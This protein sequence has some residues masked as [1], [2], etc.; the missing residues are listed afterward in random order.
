M[1]NK[2][3]NIY[4]TTTQTIFVKINCIG[5]QTSCKFFLPKQAACVRHYQLDVATVADLPDACLFFQI[6]A[7]EHNNLANNTHAN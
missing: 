4:L 3:K 1:Q 5:C 7:G 2:Y 6:A